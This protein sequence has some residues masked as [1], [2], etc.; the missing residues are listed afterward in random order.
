MPLVAY[1]AATKNLL[2]G[3]ETRHGT[4]GKKKP[5][6]AGYVRKRLVHT[7][8]HFWPCFLPRTLSRTWTLPWTETRLTPVDPGSLLHSAC[9]LTTP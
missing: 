3:H 7:V 9:G 8:F 4:E 2:V 1:G 6:F 5:H